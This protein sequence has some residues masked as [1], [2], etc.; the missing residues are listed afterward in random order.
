MVQK[1]INAQVLPNGYCRL[2]VIAGLCPHANACLD[3]TNFCTSKQFLLQHQE[4]L[5]H[6]KELLAIA[7]DKQWQRQKLIAV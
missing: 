4:H 6:K 3:C 1:N 2:P 7:K 5:R